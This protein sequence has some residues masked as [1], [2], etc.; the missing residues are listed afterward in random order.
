M[1]NDLLFD[2]SCVSIDTRMN[3]KNVISQCVCDCHDDDCNEFS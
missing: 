3:D 1:S 2:D